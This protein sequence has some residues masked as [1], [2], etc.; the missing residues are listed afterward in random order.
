MITF[1]VSI[2]SLRLMEWKNINSAAMLTQNSFLFDYL[3]RYVFLHKRATNIPMFVYQSLT[4][5][6][7][8]PEC[9]SKCIRLSVGTAFV[10]DQKNS[11]N[12]NIY[13]KQFKGISQIIM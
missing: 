12:E 7:G 9:I 5:V 13:M 3:E 6:D 1:L 2:Q 8:T 11:R 10:Q 4:I